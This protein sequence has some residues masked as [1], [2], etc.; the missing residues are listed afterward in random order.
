MSK[1][2]ERRQRI[3][4]VGMMGS[5]KTTV[6]ELLAENL[7]YDLVDIDNIIEE[8]AGASIATI[9]EQH[10]EETFRRLE[11]AVLA[12]TANRINLVFATGGGILEN[13]DNREI[14]LNSG[15]VVWLKAS[16]ETLAARVDQGENRPMLEG[17]YDIR[18]RLSQLL[19]ARL[20]NYEQAHLAIYTD[21]YPPEEIV[22]QISEY[23]VNWLTLD[24]N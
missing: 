22:R 7:N 19:E 24:E 18:G 8:H 6:G 3:F 15:L 10:G 9:F 16:L 4:L 20:P 17:H 13:D 5:G 2:A 1:N 14:I 21:R 11:S 12:D 23:Y